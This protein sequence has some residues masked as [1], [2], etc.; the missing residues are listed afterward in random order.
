MKKIKKRRLL[1]LAIFALIYAVLL[2]S[3]FDPQ[4][5]YFRGYARGGAIGIPIVIVIIAVLT[6]YYT[7]KSGGDWVKVRKNL[8]HN[9]LDGFAFSWKSNK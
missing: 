5:S 8:K 3:F 2:T 9:L 1:N 6:V 7:R 4:P